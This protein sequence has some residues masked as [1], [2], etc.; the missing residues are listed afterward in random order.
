MGAASSIPLVSTTASPYN[1][2]DE[3][4]ARTKLQKMPLHPDGLFL[5]RQLDTLA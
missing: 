1:N 5:C 4:D 2:I 3:K